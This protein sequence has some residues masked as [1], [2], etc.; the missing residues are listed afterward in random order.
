LLIH[1]VTRADMTPVAL[2]LA[3]VAGTN[4]LDTPRETHQ[5][6]QTRAAH[7]YRTVVD[8]Y[9]LLQRPDGMILLLERSGTGYADGQLCPPSGHL[10]DGESVAQTAVREASE[11]VGVD[12]DPAD[13]DF[14]HV[15]HHR[16]PEGQGRIGIFFTT[17]RW[18]GEPVN[19]EPH[20]CAR[21]CWADPARPP[22]NT[23]PYTAAALAAITE[24]AAFSLDGW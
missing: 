16:N 11:E 9:V 5:A 19:R 8:V 22:A 14:T 6:A 10:E 23:V 15:V 21:L 20:K 3:G 17:A 12:I 18:A 24:R 13:L 2:G 4:A 1:R 7:R